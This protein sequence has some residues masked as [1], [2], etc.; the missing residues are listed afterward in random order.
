ML[1]ASGPKAKDYKHEIEKYIELKKPFVIALNTDVSIN[2]NLINIFAAC[3]PLKLIADADLYQ[4]LTLPLAVPESLLSD[5][6]K[7][8]FKNLKILDFGT[9]VKENHFEFHKRGAIMPKLY[10]LVY[11][12]SIA[13]SGNA[14][15]I[16]LAGFDGYGIQDRR[17]KIIDELLYLYSSFKDAK[18]I[19]AVTPTSYS[20]ASVSIYSL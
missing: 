15:K 2:K 12:L 13:T 3:N 7:K 17:T 16:L 14:S 18:P 8:K 11:A 4:S 19:V 10:T 20:V 6:L 9:G 5:D 1:I